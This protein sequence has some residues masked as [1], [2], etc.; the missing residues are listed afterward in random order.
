VM[1]HYKKEGER[2]DKRPLLNVRETKQLLIEVLQASNLIF[3]VM[4]DALDEC[5]HPQMLL[6]IFRDV[7]HAA[8]GK[9]ELLVS[10]RPD[11]EVADK[12]SDCRKIE[13]NT[14]VSESDM[15]TFITREVKER[16]ES[17]RLLKGKRPDLE[18]RLISIL[19]RRA[20]GM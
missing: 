19:R 8:P 4:I 9:L 10:S 14:A 16:E 12:F 3:R 15:L 7:S 5:D 18:E 17:E 20:G 2:S 13:L 11:V 1:D 6:G